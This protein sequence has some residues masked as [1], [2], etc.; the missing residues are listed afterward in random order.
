MRRLSFFLALSMS[1]SMLLWAGTDPHEA[2][3]QNASFKSIVRACVDDIMY[4]HPLKSP[5]SSELIRDKMLGIVSDLAL[6]FYNESKP[7]DEA[8]MDVIDQLTAG[9]TQK[10]LLQ[11]MVTISN[12][13]EPESTSRNKRGAVSGNLW[14]YES[15]AHN[16][17]IPGPT[18][19]DA[20][21][22]TR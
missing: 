22:P 7:E 6:G 5:H 4:S 8:L 14:S 1:L 20:C 2:I 19:Q 15:I 11:K 18:G 13:N 10:I 17:F 3:L 16:R 9:S 12:W 21:G